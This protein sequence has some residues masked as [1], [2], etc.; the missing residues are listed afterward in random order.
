MNSSSKTNRIILWAVAAV[1]V[2][3]G[4]GLVISNMPDRANTAETPVAIASPPADPTVEEASQSGPA[5]TRPLPT[6]LVTEQATA[7]ARPATKA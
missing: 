2:I 5:A 7:T 4:I 1:L 6:A 3:A